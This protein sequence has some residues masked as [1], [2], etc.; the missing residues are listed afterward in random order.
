MDFINAP[1]DINTIP[2]AGSLELQPVQPSYKKILVIE[3]LITAA[4]FA[5]IGAVVVFALSKLT[6]S[7]GWLIVLAAWILLVG[8]HYFT[9]QKNFPILAF[10]VREK[11]VVTRKGWLIRSIKICPFNR[12][13]NCS[14]QSGPLERKYGLASLVIYTAGTEGADMRIAGLL[15]EEADNLRYFILSKIHKEPDENI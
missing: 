8:I 11:D 5:V 9:L 3:W 12:I 4:I 14:V 15:Q 7:Y 13:Q 10:A 6:D 2:A 1:I